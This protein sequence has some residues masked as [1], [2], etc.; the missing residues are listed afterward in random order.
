MP[1]SRALLDPFA[2]SVAKVSISRV[3]GIFQNTNDGE[4]FKFPF[5]SSNGAEKNTNGPSSP[6]VWWN[7]TPLQWKKN[8]TELW[9]PL[10]NVIHASP[11]PE[12]VQAILSRLYCQNEK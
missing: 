10:K 11:K 3:G 12:P 2:A 1:C 5:M 6:G 4:A 8:K 9:I 7:W